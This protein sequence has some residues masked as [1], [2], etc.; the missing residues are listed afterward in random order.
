MTELTARP[1]HLLIPE[2]SFAPSPFG[3]PG[4]VL[5]VNVKVTLEGTTKGVSGALVYITPVPYDWAHASE[6]VP[7]ATDGRVAV[8][9]Q[10][11]TK[12]PHQR[13]ARDADQGPRPRHEPGGDPGRHLDAP[14]RA[15]Q[16]QV[17]APAAA[18]GPC[19]ARARR[20]AGEPA[21]RPPMQFA[22]GR[23]NFDRGL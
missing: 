18:P 22:R 9:I 10:T 12:L 17:A 16:P 4:G 6:E 21:R 2:L 11:T 5:T 19:D 20:H 15:G 8:K 13:L 14:P 1:D 7:T 23:R 3:N